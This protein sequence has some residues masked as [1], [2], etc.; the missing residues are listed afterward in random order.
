M[1]AMGAGVAVWVILACCFVLGVPNGFNNLGLQGALYSV[2]P[3]E[4]I[5]WAAG[6]F[7]TFRYVGAT[8]AGAVL[9]SVFRGGATTGGLHGIATTL[10]VVAAALIVASALRQGRGDA[11]MVPG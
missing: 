8:L 9:G 3:P 10:A 4:R 2:T 1:L 6:Q 5:S 11:R 7:Q